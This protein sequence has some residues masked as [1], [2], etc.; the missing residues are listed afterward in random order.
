MYVNYRPD[1]QPAQKWEWDAAKVMADEAELMEKK[2]GDTWDSLLTAIMKGSMRGRRVLLWH[3]LRI[4]HPTVGFDDVNFAVSEVTIEFDRDE[5]QRLYDE[6][7]KSNA[8][9]EDQRGLVLAHL[10]SE[11]DKLPDGGAGAGKAPSKKRASHTR[12]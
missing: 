10:Q 11:I 2:F 7:A 12:S 4:E 5:L 3:L 1:G 6:A 9:P 8:L